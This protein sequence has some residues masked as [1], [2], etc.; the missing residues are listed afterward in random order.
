MNIG[1]APNS[2]P[3]NFFENI[4]TLEVE[5]I[6][7]RSN[8]LRNCG[9]SF[10]KLHHLK[11]L[12][13]SDN[14]YLFSSSYY[15]L[16]E[17][18]STLTHLYLNNT[19]ISGVISFQDGTKPTQFNKLEV[20]TVD[21]NSIDEIWL[22][23][24]FSQ[25]SLKHFSCSM[26]KIRTIDAQ[27]LLHASIFHMR[28]L[29]SVD[30]SFQAS[31][32]SNAITDPLPCSVFGFYSGFSSAL[33]CTCYDLSSELSCNISLPPNL[34]LIQLASSS[35]I[36]VGLSLTWTSNSSLSMVNL[37]NTNTH[38]LAYPM[39]CCEDVVI[40][41][42][43]IDLSHNSMECIHIDYF[44]YCHWTSLKH[45]YLSHNNLGIYNM[46]TTLCKDG[47]HAQLE[48]L[49]PLTKLE[50]LDLRH[51]YLLAF[52]LVMH[53]SGGNFQILDISQNII[54]SLQKETT[55]Q[56]DKAN[57][58]RLENNLSAISIDLSN[59][60]L[61]CSCENMDFYL[62]MYNTRVHLKEDYKYKCRYGL[63]EV[64]IAQANLSNVLRDFNQICHLF[65]DV[66]GPIILTFITYSIITVGAILYRLRHTVHYLW[67][68]MKL[69]RHKMEAI[70]KPFHHYHG[71]ISCDRAG[72]IWTKRHLLPK[73]EPKGT[74]LFLSMGCK[75][76]SILHFENKWTI[77]IVVVLNC[78]SYGTNSN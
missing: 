71:F 44:R 65:Q 61:V 57:S 75:S 59:N 69:N 56:F 27:N 13:L 68:K 11:M 9:K 12:D 17:L 70:L 76:E 31:S 4:T 58:W 60:Q 24:F 51:N 37:S 45:L 72:A 7:M 52:D 49:K 54:S 50:F 2:L 47:E 16:P 53:F 78:Y 74:L 63:Q 46:Y 6:C 5:V 15:E 28:H 64:N 29:V 66:W 20:L 36:Q 30:M 8:T 21:D 42:E 55:S 23:I 67:L 26:N 33:N 22:S 77:D 35:F 19:G 41:I 14:P 32:S 39:T 48:F 38:Y 25:N 43:S 18:P 10:A 73:L 3:D 34:R 40:G 62:W 1:N